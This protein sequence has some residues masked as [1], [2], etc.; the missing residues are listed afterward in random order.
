MND[1]VLILGGS[2]DIG[3]ALIERLDGRETVVAQYFGSRE[4]LA[5]IEKDRL[6][7]E[8]CDLSDSTDVDA[9]IARF[10][11]AHGTPRAVVQLAGSKLR[12]ERFAKWDQD[13]VSRDLQIQLLST[14][15]VLSA[16]APA[17]A[18][19]PVPTQVVLV[20]STVLRDPTP[21]FMS[22]YTVVKSAQLGLMRAVAAEYAGTSL[23]VHGVSPGMV[24]TRF[25][26]AI[27]E[28]AVEMTAAQA[29]NGRLLQPD[30]VAAVIATL[31]ATPHPSG[32]EVDV[33]YLGDG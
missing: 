17:M 21:K 16:F 32:I 20:L 3:L 9:L 27:P 19:S 7:V 30:E 8:R 2:S 24:A 14:A 10:R 11:D 18:K 22:M 12:L 5:E 28:K 1:R 15:R 23:R 13:H 6:F 25:L 4:R 31:L 26:S 29:P 33:P